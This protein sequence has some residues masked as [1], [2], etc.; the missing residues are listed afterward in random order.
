MFLCKFIAVNQDGHVS[1]KN[2][3]NEQVTSQSTPAHKTKT[4]K[5]LVKVLAEISPRLPLIFHE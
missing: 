3:K 2:E 5:A 1:R 4:K